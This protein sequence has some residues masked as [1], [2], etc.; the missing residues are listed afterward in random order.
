MTLFAVD[1]HDLKIFP[2]SPNFCIF[3][4]SCTILNVILILHAVFHP[5]FFFFFSAEK[6]MFSY[7]RQQADQRGYGRDRAHAIVSV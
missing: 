6:V 3:I 2:N 4:I 5:F 1:T 7:Y